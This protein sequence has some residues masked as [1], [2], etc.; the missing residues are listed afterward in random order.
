MWFWRACCN[1]DIGVFVG[2]LLISGIGLTVAA[3]AT[4]VP[5]EAVKGL[6]WPLF[7]TKKATNTETMTTKQK[8]KSRIFIVI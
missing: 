6:R 3:G 7:Q 1:A 2:A 8:I 4:L 5:I